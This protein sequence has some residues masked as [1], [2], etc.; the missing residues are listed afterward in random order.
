MIDYIRAKKIVQNMKGGQSWFGITHNCNIY[1]GCNHKCIY[2]DSRSSCYQIH[3]FDKIK[4]KQEADVMIDQELSTKRKKGVLG[5]GGMSDPYNYL[6]KELEYTRNALKSLDKYQ[7]GVHVI[8]KSTLVTRDIDILKN[9]QKHSPVGVAITITTSNDLLQG[10]IERNVPST[11]QRFEALKELSD[12][13]IYT[14]VMLMPILPFINDTEE[15]ITGIVEKAHQAGVKF[16]Y[17]SF[18]VTLRDNQRQYFFQQVGPTL[19]KQYVDTF[20]DAYACSSP[21]HKE[22]RNIFETLCKKYGI[23]YKMK[24]IVNGMSDTIKEEQISLF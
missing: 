5:L 23:V 9:I 15:N 13:G 11:S 21:K 8:T 18:G 20:G 12:N 3:E 6:E 1:R 7:F 2:C 17:A 24:D 22:L 14:G 4:V 16:I 19:T 10:R